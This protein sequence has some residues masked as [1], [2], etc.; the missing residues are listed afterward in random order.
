MPERLRITSVPDI[1]MTI[2]TLVIDTI[3]REYRGE[4]GVR[5]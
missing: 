2:S 5:W 1:R 4:A 3:L